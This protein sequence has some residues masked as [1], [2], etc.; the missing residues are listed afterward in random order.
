MR[1]HLVPNGCIRALSKTQR[2]AGVRGTASDYERKRNDHRAAVIRASE[3]NYKQ[4]LTGGRWKRAGACGGEGGMERRERKGPKTKGTN[5]AG[6]GEAE[7]TGERGR[8]MR[9]DG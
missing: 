9:E 5:G 6:Q 8:G 3:E 1:S 2:K 7:G 4:I